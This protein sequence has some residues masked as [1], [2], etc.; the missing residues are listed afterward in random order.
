MSYKS[1]PN[2]C[3]KSTA[4]FPPHRS[5]GSVDRFLPLSPQSRAPP[6]TIRRIAIPVKREGVE[7]RGGGDLWS[8]PH[9]SEE[10]FL[11]LR[12]FDTILE[13]NGVFVS[14]ARRASDGMGAC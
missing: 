10:A 14:G 8:T 2:P 13:P 5:S 3:I 4:N 6:Q 12:L 7:G 1:T 11:G 9:L